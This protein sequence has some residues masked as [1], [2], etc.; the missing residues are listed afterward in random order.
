VVFNP[1]A[2]LEQMVEI[3]VVKGTCTQVEKSYFRLT[4]A[5]DPADVRPEHVLKES[6]K[7]LKKK[8]NHKSIDY[9][10]IDDQFRSLR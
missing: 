2:S 6:L 1:S 5:P 4:S 7:M 3:L 8:W 9:K 10:Y